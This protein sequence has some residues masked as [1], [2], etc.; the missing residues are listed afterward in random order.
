MLSYA[1]AGKVPADLVERFRVIRRFDAK[2]ADV[3]ALCAENDLARAY[4]AYTVLK[5][6][7][8][9]HYFAAAHEIQ[10]ALLKPP[11]DHTTPHTSS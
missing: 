7:W 6:S 11:T 10:L 1:A 2:L 9:L 8:A 4:V 5:R 3:A